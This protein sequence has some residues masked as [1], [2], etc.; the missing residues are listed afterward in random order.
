MTWKTNDA[1]Y[2]L[3]LTANGT[4]TVTFTTNLTAGAIGYLRLESIS[5][6]N[7]AIAL[8][9]LGVLYSIKR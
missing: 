5:N 2:T 4:S 6:T 8:T 9:N 7:A 3:T 1:G